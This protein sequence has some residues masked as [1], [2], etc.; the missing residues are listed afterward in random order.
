[1]SDMVGGHVL[2]LAR[3]MIATRPA[4]RPAYQE[5]I[6]ETDK[7]LTKAIDDFSRAVSAE[8]LRLANETGTS[9]RPFRT[10][11]SIEAQTDRLLVEIWQ[12]I[13]LLALNRTGILYSQRLV[14]LQYFS[15]YWSK[16]GTLIVHTFNMQGV[17]RRFTKCVGRGTSSFY[18]PIP[19]GFTFAV[20]NTLRK[21]STFLLFLI[22]HPSSN[23]CR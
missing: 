4:G 8:A 10:G 15:T 23:G 9:L 21:F 20:R 18:P 14:H 1:M 2:D 12:D 22:Q 17:E 19:G 16:K 11:R 3:L 7:M 5:T 13:L 6:E